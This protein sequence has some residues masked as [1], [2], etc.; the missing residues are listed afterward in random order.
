MLVRLSD[1]FIIHCTKISSRLKSNKDVRW[2]PKNMKQNFCF[3]LGIKNLNLSVLLFIQHMLA[4]DVVSIQL[5]HVFDVQ[6]RPSTCIFRNSTCMFH[7]V[8]LNHWTF[9]EEKTVF[10]KKPCMVTDWNFCCCLENRITFQKNVCLLAHLWNL[11]F[12]YSWFIEFGTNT[13]IL[14][15]FLYHPALSRRYHSR[16]RQKKTI[17]SG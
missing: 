14:S 8:F 2:S 1:T 11:T 13:S 12:H 17:A 10:F 9:A 4:L 16:Y 5:S 7:V 3:L 6:V 15:C